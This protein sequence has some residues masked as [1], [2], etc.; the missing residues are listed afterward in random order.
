M[1]DTAKT[2]DMDVTP[3]ST[4]SSAIACGDEGKK[5]PPGF[6]PWLDEWGIFKDNPYRHTDVELWRREWDDV[7]RCAVRDMPRWMNVAGLWWRPAVT[8]VGPIPPAST[9]GR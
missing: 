6:M 2:A 5:P 7:R 3:R 4:A 8:I 1:T 9:E